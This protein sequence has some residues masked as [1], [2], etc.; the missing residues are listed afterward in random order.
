MVMALVGCGGTGAE[1]SP[2]GPP[3]DFFGESCRST[4]NAV[5]VCHDDRGWCVDDICR[6]MCGQDRTRCAEGVTAYT[7]EGAC[8]CAPM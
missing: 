1:T 5:T 4:S 8:Y 2:D 7:D 6:P 3:V